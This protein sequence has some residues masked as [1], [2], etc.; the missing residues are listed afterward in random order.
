MVE[1]PGHSFPRW[2]NVRQPPRIT[3]SGSVK[4]NH[5]MTD[6]DDQPTGTFPTTLQSRWVT[7][8][9]LFQRELGRR[10]GYLDAKLY[11][12]WSDLECYA[13]LCQEYIARVVRAKGEPETAFGGIQVRLDFL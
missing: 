8:S 6:F 2:I 7:T 5:D 12:Q 1:L 11:R 13:Y 10:S 4:V 9:I 3:D